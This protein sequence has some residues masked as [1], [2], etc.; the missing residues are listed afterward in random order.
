MESFKGISVKGKTFSDDS[1]VE[2][3]WHCNIDSLKCVV[4]NYSF[5]PKKHCLVS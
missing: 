2:G 4:S 5:P 3:V 1:F